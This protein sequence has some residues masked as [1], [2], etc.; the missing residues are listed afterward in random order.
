MG[1]KNKQDE[2]DLFSLL[3]GWRMDVHSYFLHI[4]INFQKANSS[5]RKDEAAKRKE[6]IKE[7][8]KKIIE[9]VKLI[10]FNNNKK[11]IK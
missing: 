1:V 6:K 11:S 5:E 10:R 4:D 3:N 2:V 7:K 9:S 8:R